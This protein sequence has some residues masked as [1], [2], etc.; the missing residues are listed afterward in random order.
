MNSLV[1]HRLCFLHFHK[2]DLKKNK[3]QSFESPKRAFS[4]VLQAWSPM[5][6]VVTLPHMSFLPLVKEFYSKSL[7]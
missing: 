4:F 3:N 6:L 2:S 1:I 7:K 5:L